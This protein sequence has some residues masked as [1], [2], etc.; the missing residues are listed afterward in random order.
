[1]PR[2]IEDKRPLCQLSS[3]CLE[4]NW[5]S[6]LLSSTAPRVAVPR[7][8]HGDLQ[9]RCSK[10]PISSVVCSRRYRE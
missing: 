10:E 3:K 7:R 8:A 5:H 1:V 9:R 2:A 4:D 6:G